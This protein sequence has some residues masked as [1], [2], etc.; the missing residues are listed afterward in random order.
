[1]RSS[2]LLCW[3]FAASDPWNHF[4][5][6]FPKSMPWKNIE[7]F[8]VGSDLN[9]NP[10]NVPSREAD[11]DKIKA[12]KSRRG[13]RKSRLQVTI[14]RC[15]VRKNPRQGRKSWRRTRAIWRR[16]P[17]NS[18]KAV[19]NMPKVAAMPENEVTNRESR[20]SVLRKV[21]AKVPLKF[22]RLINAFHIQLLYP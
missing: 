12:R 15:W 17:H 22:Q 9:S 2:S 14:N 10:R 18:N 19:E 6:L 21:G 8:C 20:R 13:S 4:T 11:Q 1:M 3:L 5:R 7:I 16:Y